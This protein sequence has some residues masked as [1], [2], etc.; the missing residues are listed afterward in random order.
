MP[1]FFVDDQL[2][3][4]AKV[5]KAGTPALGLWV[6]CGAWSAGNL[7]DGFVPADIAARYGT[8]R[9]AE[10]L[11]AA[12]LWAPAERDGEPGYQFWDWTDYQQTRDQVRA[13]RAADAERQ[14]RRRSAPDGE[15][16]SAENI[17]ENTPQN[18]GANGGVN[19]S[20]SDDEKSGESDAKP[21]V[22]DGC[23]GVTHT[24]SHGCPLPSPPAALPK[25]SAAARG[26]G[27]SRKPS[28]DL[29]ELSNAAVKPA[30]YT[31]VSQWR[32]K[33]PDA[34]P[35][36]AKTIRDLSKVVDG[37]LAQGAQT[38]L[39]LAALDEWDARTDVHS[40]GA[41]T[42]LYG[43]AVKAARGTRSGRPDGR[44][45]RGSKVQGWLSLGDDPDAPQ[46]KSA[47]GDK[48]RGWLDLED[49]DQAP[50][51]KAITGGLIA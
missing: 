36:L 43:D 23:H 31:L 41:L 28:T 15:T 35:Y 34:P 11:V 17:P 9:Q 51:L 26:R 27:R 44:Q 18:R 6:R 40:P 39:V 20:E 21:Q 47:R 32:Q 45:T 25:G 12:G 5:R 37:L 8:A 2:A 13:R 48:V 38:D 24:V 30:A 7:T 3:D 49:D 22:E 50:A 16:S 1:W 19:V 10:K 42:W 29:A 46:P 14:R 4:N 33:Y